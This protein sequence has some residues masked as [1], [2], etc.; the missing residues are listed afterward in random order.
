MGASAFTQKLPLLDH[1]PII[2]E[3]YAA[4]NAL[5]KSMDSLITQQSIDKS[6]QSAISSGNSQ[7]LAS[8]FF[9]TI[10]LSLP[11]AQGSFSKTQAE[12][13]IKTFFATY[14]PKSLTII[15]EGQSGGEKSRYAIGTYTSVNGKSFRVYY[16]TKEIN[17]KQL[18]T[19][20]KFE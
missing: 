9:S 10:E 7:Q 5:E 2:R 1:P 20:L 16:L 15:N 8:Y 3:I 11:D 18:L 17:G 12:L 4:T 6:I 14:P 13:L 19:I